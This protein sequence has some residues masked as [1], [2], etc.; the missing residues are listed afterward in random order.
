[1][2]LEQLI[3]FE[4]VCKYGA[5]SK[6][7]NALYVSQSTV[8]TAIAHLEKELS[9]TL[10][11]RSKNGVALTEQESG[12]KVCDIYGDVAGRAYTEAGR[13]MAVLLEKV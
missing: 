5:I 9:L 1:M 13:T 11:K 6:A 7:A 8:S 10:F 2:N 3:Y 12:F 4:A